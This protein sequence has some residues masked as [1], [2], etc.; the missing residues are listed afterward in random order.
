MGSFNKYVDKKGWVNGQSD[1]YIGLI[2]RHSKKGPKCLLLPTSG[3]WVVKKTP[4][5]SVYIM[6]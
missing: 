1:V 3:R 2:Y 5:N 6:F 4:E